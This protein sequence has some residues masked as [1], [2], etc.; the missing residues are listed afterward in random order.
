MRGMLPSNKS[1]RLG[2]SV[3][4]VHSAKEGG[5]GEK[6]TPRDA[7]RQRLNRATSGFNKAFAKPL[8][9]ALW[10]YFG[11]DYSKESRKKPVRPEMSARAGSSFFVTGY[12]GFY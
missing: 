1:E 12:I 11:S 4:T 5:G 2:A 3:S 8:V 9:A 6:I 7:Q 10:P